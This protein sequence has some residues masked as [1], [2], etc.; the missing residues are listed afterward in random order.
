MGDRQ[1][2]GF[3]AGAENTTF[4][5]RF[6]HRGADHVVV[7]V[8]LRTPRP[9]SLT[10]AEVAVARELVRGR[11]NAEIARIRSTSVHTVANQVA[12]LMAKLGMTSRAQIALHLATVDLRILEGA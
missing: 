7:T 2:P 4:A 6:R 9:A 11:S 10:C 8:L 3:R 12:S 5:Y 1:E